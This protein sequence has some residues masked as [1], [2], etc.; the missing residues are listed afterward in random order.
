MRK[1]LREEKYGYIA[2]TVKSAIN[3]NNLSNIEEIRELFS[4]VTNISVN[5]QSDKFSDE[6]KNEMWSQFCEEYD[7]KNDRSSVLKDERNHI[8]WWKKEG[9][10]MN[11]ARWDRYRDYLLES[12]PSSV[13]EEIDKS[14]D[15]IIGL[16]EDPSREG[17]WDT[18][19]LVVGSVQSGKTSNYIGLINKALDAEYKLVI[20]L[21]GL[22]NDLRSQTQIRVDEGLL[23]FDS[24]NFFSGKSHIYIGVGK[25]GEKDDS[26]RLPF[27]TSLTNSSANGDFSKTTVS[28]LSLVPDERQIIAV[29]K[30]NTNTLEHIYKWLLTLAQN[31]MIDNV[32]LLMI[33][34]EADN[35][36]VD[37]RTP[38]KIDAD[39]E[40]D[41]DPTA[42]NRWIRQILNLF[43]K[44]AYV[45]YTATPYANVFIYPFVSN[46]DSYFG[47]DLFPKNFIVNLKAPSNYYGPEMIFGLD[48]EYSEEND[49]REPLPLVREISD[50]TEYFPAKQSKNF[51]IKGIPQSLKTAILTFILSCAARI[52]RGESHK[53]ASMLIHVTRFNEPQGTLSAYVNDYISEI[54]RTWRY[55]TG[56][57]Y[58]ELLK[59]MKDL[60]ED[61]FVPT[62]EAV[63]KDDRVNDHKIIRSSW[64]EIEKHINRVFERIKVEVINGEKASGGLDYG[65]N[66][67]SPKFVIAIGGDKLSRGLTLPG[68]SVS[69][70][71]RSSDNYDTL[72]Q[73]GRWFGYKAGFLDLSRIFTSEDIVWKYK[74]IAEADLDLRE[75]LDNMAALG[76]TPMEFGLSIKDAEGRFSITAANKMKNSVESRGTYLGE[77]VSTKVLERNSGKNKHNFEVTEK[78]IESLK[79]TPERSNETRMNYLWR[80]IPSE[81]VIQYLQKLSL[82]IKNYPAMP[83]ELAN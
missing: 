2:K 29:I 52:E 5:F 25:N 7:V 57:L 63:L 40:V 14:T 62:T 10:P 47:E 69:Y 75:S 78:F 53:K 44:S 45:G 31:H 51:T 35:A 60:W 61:D 73:M 22:N 26:K 20:I 80:N 79:G 58:P 13:V 66:P 37:Y 82:P 30:K 24:A 46:E 83:K 49:D 43:N 19:G 71:T 32:P 55:K 72:Y 3:L 33:D 17:K 76:K 12:L 8:E 77:T 64:N 54:K 65:N 11:L 18:R 34:D 68:L 27:L 16:L 21:A 28:S 56:V 38:S 36:S 42:I 81:E 1:D 48:K 67:E 70:F 74:Q 4:V 50:F 59:S 9:T 39:E 41:D 23:G 6:E 15:E